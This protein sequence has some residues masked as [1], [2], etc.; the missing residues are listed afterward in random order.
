MGG[1]GVNKLQRDQDPTLEPKVVTT[2]FTNKVDKQA[3]TW[4]R[5][6]TQGQEPTKANALKAKLMTP[7]VNSPNVYNSKKS[8][9]DSKLESTRRHM[10]RT[11]H[12]NYE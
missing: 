12:T 11:N 7:F 6:A 2:M 10:R 3:N 9:Q 1:R 8:N 5:C 4:D